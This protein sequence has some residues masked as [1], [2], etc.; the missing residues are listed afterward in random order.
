MFHNFFCYYYGVYHSTDQKIYILFLDKGVLESLGVDQT[1]VYWRTNIDITKLVS[2]V[3]CSYKC[4]ITSCRSY[5]VSKFNKEE[6]SIDGV[7][8]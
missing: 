3:L 2:G 6:W 1:K 8:F 7:C 5:V 4:I